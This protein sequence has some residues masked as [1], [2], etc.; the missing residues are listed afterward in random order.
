[1]DPRKQATKEN[2]SEISNLYANDYSRDFHHFEY[3]DL[4]LAKID[5]RNLAEKGVTDLGSGHGTVIE[6]ILEK[7]HLMIT[8]VDITPEFCRMLENKFD[9]PPVRVVQAD[10]VDHVK[11]LDDGST[12]AFT[13]NF[14]LIHI[15]DEETDVLLANISA[16]LA[17]GGLFMASV[18]EGD[19]KGMMAERYQ[20]ENDPRLYRIDKRLEVYMNFFKPEEVRR[21]LEAAGLTILKME[22]FDP[23]NTV[24]PTDTAKRI[25]FLAE[26]S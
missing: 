10:M 24:S 1:M 13:A 14:S 8:A 20:A 3:I 6:Y 12:G 19:F 7:K 18:L 23:V 17:P 15:P 22:S 11:N 26:K 16:K 9:N 5:E 25:F 2:Y 21:R 4:M